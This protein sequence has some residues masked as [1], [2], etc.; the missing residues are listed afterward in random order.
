VVASSG[1][2]W[3]DAWTGLQSAAAPRAIAF[4]AITPLHGPIRIAVEVGGR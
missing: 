2:R 3:L 4:E 1:A